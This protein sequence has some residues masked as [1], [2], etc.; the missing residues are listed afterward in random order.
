MKIILATHNMDKVKE[1]KDFLKTYEI[2]A[3]NEILTPFEIEETGKTFK[4][5][6][7]IKSKAIFNALDKNQI[8]DF[9]TLSD[10][11]GI[12]L[13]VLGGKPGIYSARFSGI[14][15]TDQSNRTKLI[16]ELNALNLSKTPAF[17]T[18]CIAISSKFGDYTTHG[19]MNGFA[20]NKE[21]GNNGFGYDFMFIPNGFD[22]TVGEIDQE[23]KLKISHRSRGLELMKHI[24]KVL[25]KRY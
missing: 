23:T 22:K 19:F 8:N 14:N 12:S 16:N 7:L 25:E 1:I 20:I 18:A 17:Y 11:S 5:N 6:A 21:R 3:L 2:Y 9:I 4:E 24:L 10:D 13:P 15:A